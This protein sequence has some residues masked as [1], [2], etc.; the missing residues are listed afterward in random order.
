VV[1]SGAPLR[2]DVIGFCRNSIFFSEWKRTDNS[3]GNSNGGRC[4]NVDGLHPTHR[5]VR[6]GWGTETFVAG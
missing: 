1:V 2:K 3:K 4:G 5:R 6:D